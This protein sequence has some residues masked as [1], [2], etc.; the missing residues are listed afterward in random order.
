MCLA[1]QDVAQKR[2]EERG[3]LHVVPERLFGAKIRFSGKGL[4]TPEVMHF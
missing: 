2:Q 1:D 3:I 4:V